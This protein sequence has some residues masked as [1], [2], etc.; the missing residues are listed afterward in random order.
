[1]CICLYTPLKL[2]DVFV[3]DTT[4][5]L[6]LLILTIIATTIGGVSY[7][8]FT[9]VFKVEEIQLLYKLLNKLKLKEAKHIATLEI[10]ENSTN[11]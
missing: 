6:N 2:L 5:T 8:F 1:M 7:L 11:I 10:S 9:W 4:K 3:L